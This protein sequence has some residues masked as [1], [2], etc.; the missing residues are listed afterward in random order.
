[1]SGRSDCESSN[2]AWRCSGSR[3]RA[4][5]SAT[6]QATGAPLGRW[7]L[8]R[9]N[10]ADCLCTSRLNESCGGATFNTLRSIRTILKT[11]GGGRPQATVQATVCG[12]IETSAA[13]SP[14]THAGEERQFVAGPVI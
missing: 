13:R 10:W 1:M 7:L 14:L 11:K 5:D 3:R 12:N 2:N 8:A 4:A 9:G 6:R